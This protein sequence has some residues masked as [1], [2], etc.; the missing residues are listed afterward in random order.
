MVAAQNLGQRLVRQ[1]DGVWILALG[2][3]QHPEGLKAA[4]RADDH[5]GRQRKG[6]E[7]RSQPLQF[8]CDRGFVPPVGGRAVQI[9]PEE[10][11]PGDVA[12][13][14][15][16]GEM[17]LFGLAHQEI[18]VALVLLAPGDPA[19]GLVFPAR[20]EAGRARSPLLGDRRQHPRAAR[21]E[22]LQEINGAGNVVVES[23]AGG[24]A[25]LTVE[26]VAHGPSF[27]VFWDARVRRPRGREK[28]C[29]RCLSCGLRRAGQ[30]RSEA[31]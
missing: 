22:S 12:L 28:R 17:I 18:D 13:L 20:A 15:L 2:N 11:H 23:A 8:G 14:R 6:V 25:L 5:R 3:V 10:T 31:A 24:Q 30:N 19:L 9:D 1:L 27:A 26:L 29:H 4:A 16:L 21:M 7:P